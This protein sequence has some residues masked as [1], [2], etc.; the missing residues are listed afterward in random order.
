MDIVATASLGTMLS[1][2]VTALKDAREIAKGS[3][4]YE[5]KAKI[6]LQF[7][8]GVGVSVPKQLPQRTYLHVARRP[9]LINERAF[10]ILTLLLS[11]VDCRVPSKIQRTAI[12]FSN[13]VVEFFVL[14]G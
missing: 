7:L 1:T 5:L 9:V 14:S 10:R 2:A 11:H 6:R 12:S 4:D 13:P 8:S 3:A